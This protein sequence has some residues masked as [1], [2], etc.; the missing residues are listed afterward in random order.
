ML[1]VTGVEIYLKVARHRL[2]SGNKE[3][4]I[5]L[6][7]YCNT[8]LKPHRRTFRYLFV[9]AAAVQH[10]VFR[11]ETFGFLEDCINLIVDHIGHLM[12]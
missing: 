9:K 10:V 3:D 4:I 1:A 6:I 5:V 7:Y 8:A 2:Q 11:L 12:R